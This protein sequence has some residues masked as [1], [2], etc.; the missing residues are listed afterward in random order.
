MDLSR[1]VEIIQLCVN[2]QEQA[3]VTGCGRACSPCVRQETLS[4]FQ[5]VLR[6]RLVSLVGLWYWEKKPIR[7]SLASTVA[8]ES[9]NRLG[10]SYSKWDICL[11]L[12]SETIATAC[13][14]NKRVSSRLENKAAETMGAVLELWESGTSLYLQGTHCSFPWV[15]PKDLVDTPVRRR[16]TGSQGSY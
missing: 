4:Q 6:L 10:T 14:G 16:G 5:N 8:K 15:W 2:E 3:Q 1:L 12:M 7:N 11:L 13:C 9:W